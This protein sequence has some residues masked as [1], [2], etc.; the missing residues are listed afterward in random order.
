MALENTVS[1]NMMVTI[2]LQRFKGEIGSKI[3]VEGGGWAMGLMGTVTL[4][5]LTTNNE[6]QDFE[7]EVT[8]IMTGNRE[9]W[10]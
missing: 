8:G 5:H 6:F 3:G 2:R 10:V 1:V 7:M 4:P 9:L